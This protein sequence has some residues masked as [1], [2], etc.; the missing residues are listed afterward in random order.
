MITNTDKPYGQVAPFYFD[1]PVLHNAVINL[2]ERNIASSS[3]SVFLCH[4][5]DIISKD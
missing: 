3:F 4:K 1:L 2:T 5:L